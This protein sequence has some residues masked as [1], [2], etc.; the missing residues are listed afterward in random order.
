[1]MRLLSLLL[2][3]VMF[4]GCASYPKE[5]S[6]GPIDLDF[7][8][9]Q[10]LYP[11]ASDDA[12]QMIV[13]QSNIERTTFF[14]D[15]KSV[16]T[17]RRV[18]VLVNDRKEHTIRAVPEGYLAKEEF[19]QPPYRKGYLL[20]FTYMMGEERPGFRV[21]DDRVQ[22]VASS[23]VDELP[24]KGI[25]PTA[26]KF[27]I[28]VGVEKYRSDLPPADY[29]ANDATAVYNYATR[30][31]GYPAKNVVLLT[32]DKATK[33]D[34]EKYFGRWLSN[35][36]TPKSEVL[37]Y[38]SG[39]GA[40]NTKDGTSFLVPYDADPAFI[41]E[42]GYPLKKLYG[43]LSALKAKSV[44]VALDSCFSGYGG[45]SVIPKG[46]RPLVLTSEK[47]AQLGKNVA[48]MTA[49]STNQVSSTYKEKAHGLFTYFFLKSIKE[50][51]QKGRKPCE[52]QALFKDIQPNV[53]DLA[54]KQNNVEQTP[55]L[56]YSDGSVKK[57]SLM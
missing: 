47:E 1:M 46:T 11:K 26:S 18:K 42:T 25:R 48:V 19:I 20:S 32:N 17:G 36:V 21:Q 49:T 43:Q 3:L 15:G 7:S 27:A 13:L 28:I 39:H 50:S 53:M 35:N 41:E 54:R 8:N 30:V 22:E 44:V 40:P 37:V 38:Y 33:S 24:A 57:L 55:Q 51:A 6:I 45:R 29:A 52:L 16:A 4:A 5:I 14:V 23:D 12:N 34:F 2:C 31:M 56:I 10:E 9:D